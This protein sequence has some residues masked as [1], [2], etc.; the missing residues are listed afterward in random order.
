LSDRHIAEIWPSRAAMQEELSR[1]ARTQG[2][3]LLCPPFYTFDTLL[4]ELLAQAPLP[5]GNRPLLPL[6]GP[7]LVQELLRGSDQEVYAGLAAGRRLPERLWRLLVEVKA[8]G[9]NSRDLESLGVGGSRFKALAGLLEGYEKV[10]SEKG[11]ADQADQL[12]ALER[13]LQTGF[14][15]VL[16]NGW[17]QIICRGVLW[18]RSLD[19]RMIRALAGVLELRVEF[20]IVP[21]NG[22][23][24]NLQRLIE[25]TASALEAAPY[26][27]H[28][29]IAWQDLR[30]E[31]GPLKDLIASHLDQSIPYKGQ[32]ADRV[33]LVAAAGRYGL[34]EEMA[35]RAYDSVKAGV[36]P[37]E[38][39]LVFPDLDVYGPMVGDA[40]RRMGLPINLG[41]GLP[42]I[43]TPLV[44]AILA[45]LELPLVHYERRALTDVFNSPYLRG[46]LQRA[47]LEPGETLLQDVGYLLKRSG[48]LDSRDVAA[49]DWL[50]Q[51]AEREETSNAGSKRLADEYRTLAKACKV[52][53]VKLKIIT[54]SIDIN[55]YYNGIYSLVSDLNPAATQAKSLGSLAG[56]CA[57]A[58]A[59]QARDLTALSEFLRVVRDIAQA[60][61]QA[62]AHEKQSPGRL[63]ALLK[64]VLGKTKISGGS[65]TALGVSV[66]R[67]A[68]TMGIKPRVVLVGGLNQGEF[69]IRPKGQ[70]LLSSAQR[71][72]L[73]RKAKRPVWRADDEEYEGQL[74]QLAWLLANCSERAILGAA[75]ADLSGRQQ[76]PS[77]VLEDMAR[78]LGRE[79]PT[80]S[81]GVFGELPQLEKVRES[82]ALWGRLSAGLL[83]PSQPDTGLAQAA[84]WHLSQKRAQSLG[85]QDLANRGQHEEKRAKLNELSLQ[86]RPSRGSAFS[87][88]FK[89]EQAHSLLKQVLAEPKL[90]RLSPSA[91]ETY[92]ACPF[93]WYLSYLLRLRVLEEPGWALEARSE[94]EWV[95]RALAQ[96]FD[97]DEFDPNWDQSAQA[98]RLG[99][100]LNKAKSEL[101]AGMAAPP[102]VWEA[103]H[104][105]LQ[106]ALAHVVAGEMETMAGALPWAVERDID[107]GLEITVDGGPPLGLKGRLDRLDQGPKKAVITDY[108]H[109]ANE[110]GLREAT[111]KDLAGVSQF[112]LPVYMAAALEMMDGQ[113]KALTG[114]LVPTLLASSKAREISF[115]AN[116]A[117]FASDPD[118]RQQLAEQN[119]PNLFN[120]IADLWQ[121][122][123]A[124]DFVALPDKLACGYCDYRLACRAK[125]PNEA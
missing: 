110:A 76:A 84:L 121:R 20:A 57:P 21:N 104:E 45:L 12:A 44:L 125:A 95:H 85:W 41:K 47:C 15:P 94:G 72:R 7:M 93:A 9:L 18:L 60:S 81:G 82:S 37:D 58:Q 51:A 114:R 88:R 26:P 113:G 68:D 62:G 36:P 97:P 56:S 33:E 19:I 27:E 48:Y 65:G 50:D 1:R 54:Q 98:E 116:H 108:K 74:L 2:G 71:L 4:P 83:R 96:F 122:L 24:K 22:G 34:A 46:P 5:N 32:G 101:S 6:T 23:Q 106:K 10:L 31:G 80:P 52:L 78:L 35:A 38:V 11:L 89:S 120:A 119:K 112:Q 55:N 107:Q 103:R 67:L 63:L 111:D 29:E 49:E 40:A 124:G 13:M 73:G 70:N 115:K 43:K 118:I 30:Q 91:L 123:T 99:Q 14:K 3:L 17:Q 109:T 75:G 42:L 61:D 92:A 39:A 53:K 117:F 77:F 90:R 102:A 100:S 69:P 64:E 87:G 28:L 16:L 79:L 86:I 25:A 59:I 8:A 105:V 66:H